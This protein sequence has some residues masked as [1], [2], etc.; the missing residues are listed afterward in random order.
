MSDPSLKDL[1]LGLPTWTSKCTSGFW[2]VDLAMIVCPYRRRTGQDLRVSAAGTFN[3]NL[4][5]SMHR[6]S[7]KRGTPS[8]IHTTL[9]YVIQHFLDKSSFLWN[10]LGHTKLCGFQACL[11]HLH[12]SQAGH[13][14]ATP[15]FP[16][17]GAS[18]PR[19]R[20]EYRVGVLSCWLQ[21]VAPLSA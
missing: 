1:G 12:G 16:A 14:R 5:F 6:L 15:V 9:T 13:T 21:G 11:E 19:I 17:A 20:Q 8:P 2:M 10:E 7:R 4:Q 3:P 18:T